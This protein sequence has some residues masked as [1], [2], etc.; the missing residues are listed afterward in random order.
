MS[1]LC[2]VIRKRACWSQIWGEK[3]LFIYHSG[4]LFFAE[5]LMKL[6][7]LYVSCHEHLSTKLL[8]SFLVILFFVKLLRI[9]FFKKCNYPVSRCTNVIEWLNGMCTVQQVTSIYLQ[10]YSRI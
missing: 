8:Y 4:G 3:Q 10:P 6:I 1:D 2:R 7:L 5:N 9:N